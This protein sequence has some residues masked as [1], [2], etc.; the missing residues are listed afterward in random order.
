MGAGGR[1]GRTV[2]P[3]GAVR[4]RLPGREP[5]AMSLR[6]WAFGSWELI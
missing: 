1:C 4:N 5:C 3:K 6:R 2:R